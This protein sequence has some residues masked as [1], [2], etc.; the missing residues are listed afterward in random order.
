[1]S[2]AKYSFKEC[3]LTRALRAA[4]KAGH[5]V[6]IEIDIERRC[7]RIMPI[8]AKAAQSSSADLDEELKEF[9]KRHG[10]QVSS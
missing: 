7:M 6:I 10:S 3:D 2:R 5:E 8:K 4:D 9:E 1:M